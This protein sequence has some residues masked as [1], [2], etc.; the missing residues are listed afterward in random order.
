MQLQDWGTLGKEIK[1]ILREFRDLP[2]HVIFIAQEIS[3][4]NEDKIQKILPSLNGKSATDIAYYM[5]VV[6]Y[7]YIDKATG[8]RMIN[9]T[10]HSLYLTKDR[11]N[12]IE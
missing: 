12:V 8:K 6:G 10:P 5:D 2:M 9:T 4:K 1:T 3:E 7:A 11:T